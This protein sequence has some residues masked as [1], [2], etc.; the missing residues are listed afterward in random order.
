MFK[1]NCGCLGHV[2]VSLTANLFSQL[3]ETAVHFYTKRHGVRIHLFKCVCKN[4]LVPPRNLAKLFTINQMLCALESRAIFPVK[5]DLGSR[6]H[7]YSFQSLKTCQM[8]EKTKLSELRFFPCAE[9]C[10][11]SKPLNHLP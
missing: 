2:T 10:S 5:R 4:A 1:P 3:R 7:G 6:G 8:R 9:I 11:F